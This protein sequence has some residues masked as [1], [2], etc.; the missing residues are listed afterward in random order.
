MVFGLLILD[1][2]VAS[3]VMPGDTKLSSQLLTDY[4]AFVDVAWLPSLAVMPSVKKTII[5]ANIH[6]I[7]Y[8][9]KNFDHFVLSFETC[10]L[11]RNAYLLDLK[12]NLRL[13]H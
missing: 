7:S 10:L 12:F 11:S 5:V 4:Q 2:V 1:S 8:K 13:I 3:T 6:V 9:L